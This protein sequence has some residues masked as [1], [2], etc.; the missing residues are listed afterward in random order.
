MIAL[1]ILTFFF[2]L[3][4]ITGIRARK[5][6]Q[7]TLENWAVG[8]R[9]FNTV[10]VFLLTAGEVYTTFSFLGGSGW[11]YS[12]GVSAVYVMVYIALSYVTSYFLL[13]LIWQ[14]ANEHKLVSQSDFFEAKYQSKAL[15]VLV[16]LTGVIAIIP[17]IVIQLKGLAIIV[18]LT[19]YGKIPDQASV[20]IGVLAIIIY[21]IVSGIRGVAWVSVLKDFMI[22]I[23][24][25]FM[26]VYLPIHYFGSYNELFKQVE[27]LKPELLTFP[28]TG[29]T[30][31]W[32]ISTV[33][34]YVLG[35]YMWPQVFASTF[36]AKSART[37]RKNAIIS[38][39]YTLMLL[40]VIFIG[41]TAVIKVPNLAE[42]KSDL[43]LLQLAIQS[44]DPWFVGII[45]A[46]GMLTALV[47]GSM[48]LMTASTL[49]SKNII[50]GIKS[51]TSDQNVTRLSKLFIPVIGIISCLLVFHGSSALA[52]I[53]QVGY[54][55]IVQLCPALFF[56]LSKKN[57]LTKEG[58]I[59]GMLSGIFVALMI[60][61]Y[62]LTT[63]VIFPYLPHYLSDINVGFIPLIINLVVGILISLFVRKKVA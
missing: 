19:S 14:Y 7:M 26:G 45:G 47:P 29:Y 24:I 4:V 25:V 44:F 55:L 63:S 2:I 46:A 54:S 1:I 53:L 23:V 17:I 6:Q 42:G 3:T 34:F 41:F 37:F 30:V 49:L 52:A 16:A 33:L 15:G 50:Y 8:G 39:I 58:A 59:A 43:A 48:L 27:Y 56:S 9:N 51:N 18:S 11:T 32:F 31:T 13:P 12:N 20:I 36:T 22:L 40:F 38:P 35:F 62:N 57:F 60:S 61:N 21:S 10:F 5:K 28:K